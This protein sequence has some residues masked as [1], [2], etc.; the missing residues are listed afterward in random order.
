MKTLTFIYFVYLG[1][2]FIS[3]AQKFRKSCCIS[4]V[5]RQS[6][7][8]Q[9][10]SKYSRLILEDGSSALGLSRMGKTCIVAEFHRTDLI[11]CSHSRDG[12]TL[13]YS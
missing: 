6:F 5:I 1:P 3:P 11:I 9:K 13:S 12:E 7:S 8:F 4:S 10:Q 2:V